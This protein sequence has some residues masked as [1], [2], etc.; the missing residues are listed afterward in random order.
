M[1][2][3]RVTFSISVSPM[4]LDESAEVEG[5]LIGGLLSV[6]FSLFFCLWTKAMK[7]AS[8]FD[9][10][11]RMLKQ[12]W[13]QVYDNNFTEVFTLTQD[14]YLFYRLFQF[15]HF[16][17]AKKVTTPVSKIARLLNNLF[18]CLILRRTCFSSSSA[19]F[20]STAFSANFLR[21]SMSWGT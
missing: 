10:T 1:I 11:P 8:S 18:I 9:A 6:S 4:I 15:C 16:G 17:S 19:F 3:H 7:S 13:K 21:T 5:R 2:L 20:S 14:L 12:I